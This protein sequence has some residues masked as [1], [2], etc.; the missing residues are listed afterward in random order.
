MGDLNTEDLI[1]IAAEKLFLE[2][3]FAMTST[4]DIARQAE[5]NTAMIHYYFRTKNI[6]FDK[7][8]E[9]KL[10]LFSESFAAIPERGKTFEDRLKLRVETHF[11]LLRANP[12]LPFLI[13]N[14]MTTNSEC[15]DCFK[16]VAAEM[17]GPIL[18]LL[19]NEIDNEVAIGKIRDIKAV[20]LMMNIGSLNVATFLTLPVS[21]RIL[22]MDEAAINKFLDRRKEE[23]SITILNS[24]KSLPLTN[25]V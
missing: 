17:F 18:G 8:Y 12:K 11:E 14:E 23:I 5:C 10:R 15:Y 4:A 20:D 1:L 22:N 13:L 3:G 6:L 7:I 2:K 24:V 25:L 21:S 9:K 16:N 19:Q